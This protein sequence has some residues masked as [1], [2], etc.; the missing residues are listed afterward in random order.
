LSRIV[1]AIEEIER[2]SGTQFDPYC[3]HEFLVVIDEHR[4]ELRA[5][6]IILPE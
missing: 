3:A 5:K 1:V 6:G 4:E 2:C